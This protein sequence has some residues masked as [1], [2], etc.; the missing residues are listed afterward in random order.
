[1]KDETLKFFKN[2]P[3]QEAIQFNE[4]LSLF[5]R[6][7]GANSRILIQMNSHGYSPGRLETLLHELKKM[8]GITEKELAMP[9]V[10]EVNNLEVIISDRLS[11]LSPKDSL[12]KVVDDIAVTSIADV[13][14]KAPEEVKNEIK[15]RDDFP[16]LNSPDCPNEFKILT[17]DKL[18]HY[19]NYVDAH[20]ALLVAIPEGEEGGVLAEPVALT[21][22]EIFILAKAAVENFTANQDI[23]NELEC[24]KNTGKLL[25]KHPLIVVLKKKEMIEKE[26]S[27]QSSKRVANL[28]NYINR[29]LA[30]FNLSLD[31]E[32]KAV[33]QAKIDGW[34][35]EKQM[36]E[37]KLKKDAK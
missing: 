30:E 15:L 34:N 17:A 16:F 2:L 23:Y 18:T 6:S 36:V 7:A 20:K 14:L 13:F 31:N 9:L 21:N 24:Y 1:M 28:V 10:V 22:D 19:H 32:R 26:S 12:L 27:L 3:K 25:G 4:A 35:L 29:A 33:L 8:H 11:F 5:R 37:E